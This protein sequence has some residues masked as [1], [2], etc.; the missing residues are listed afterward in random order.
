MQ[1]EKKDKEER[2]RGRK[3]G[4]KRERKKLGGK[5][6]KVTEDR[7]KNTV[8]HIQIDN[9]SVNKVRTEFYVQELSKNKKPQEIGKDKLNK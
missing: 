1:E 8:I 3:E 9:Y 7:R 5:Q 6:G 4:K 2:K